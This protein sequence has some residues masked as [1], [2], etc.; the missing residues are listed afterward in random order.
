[1]KN[2]ELTVHLQEVRRLDRSSSRP[3]QKI[4]FRVRKA[5][6]IS[7]TLD[8]RNRSG[9]N[10]TSTRNGQRSKCCS[11]QILEASSNGMPNSLAQASSASTTK[12]LEYNYRSSVFIGTQLVRSPVGQAY[13]GKGKDKQFDCKTDTKSSAKLR[14]SPCSRTVSTCLPDAKSI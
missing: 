6:P 5:R 12:T 2:S 3:C 8:G 4:I 10:F 9:Y 11:S 1:M 14:M 7:F 13:P